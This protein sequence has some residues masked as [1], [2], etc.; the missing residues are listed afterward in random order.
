MPDNSNKIVALEK[1]NRFLESKGCRK[2]PERKA[3]LEAAISIDGHFDVD[4]LYNMLL[5]SPYKVVKTTI[6][7]NLELLIECGILRKHIFTN[8]AEYERID[9]KNQHIHLIC[10]V[11]GKV[12]DAKD[13]ELMRYLKSKKFSAFNA[14]VFSM[15]VYGICNN[16]ARKIKKQ[17]KMEEILKETT[18]EKAKKENKLKK[19]K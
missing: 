2:T 5:D 4:I 12:K 9:A 13:L 16:C 3:I 7:S 19:N 15:S 8:H 18:V 11:C 14:E 6:Y 1:F 17:Q 10:N